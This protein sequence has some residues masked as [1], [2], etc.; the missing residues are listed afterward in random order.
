MKLEQVFDDDSLI[1]ILSTCGLGNRAISDVPVLIAEAAQ[2]R[3]PGNMFMR[4]F[5]ILSAFGQDDVALQMQ[6][7][8]L[9]HRRIYRIANPPSVGIRLLAIMGPGDMRDNTPL[10]YLIE[11]S[12]IR[13]D[14]LFVSAEAAIPA[15]IPGHDVAFI[16]LSEAQKNKP[17]LHKIAAALEQWPRPYINHPL[18]IF[19]CARDTA[20]R[21]LQDVPGLYTPVTYRV[22]RDKAAEHAF[23]LTIR[24]LD[25]H[26]GEGLE[27]INSRDELDRYLEQ[28]VDMEEFYISEFVD[29][30]SDDGCYRKS[31]IVLIDRKPYICHFAISGDWIVH[32]ANA[33]MESSE[34]KRAEEA[35][36]MT[37]FDTDFAARHRD[38]LS[39][40]AD[41]LNLDYVVIDCGETRNGELLFFE[42]DVVGWV[43]ATDA[44]DIFPYKPLV[45][46][47]AFDA[48]RAM[49]MKKSGIDAIG[50]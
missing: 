1:T 28:Q 26:R 13:L 24:P 25:K 49:L 9:A 6:S 42:A 40:I 45:M 30:R 34:A 17:I 16:A 47:K 31:R 12:D 39:A 41:R 29:Y 8:A 35:W 7:K 18:H 22:R 38:A 14:L 23:P 36:F 44:V 43:H 4:M 20:S 21:L 50:R 46:Q 32:Y 3:D 27:R 10:D 19:N 11:R 2:D 33:H 48:F 15:A 37:N 5:Y